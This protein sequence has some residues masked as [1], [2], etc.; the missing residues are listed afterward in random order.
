MTH[1]EPAV[2]RPRLFATACMI[3]TLGAC[4]LSS[5]GETRAQTTIRDIDRPTR[6]PFQIT[7]ANELVAEP[8]RIV[9]VVNVPLG[10]RLVIEHASVQV[11]VAPTPDRRSLVN[12]FLRTQ[13]GGEVA[14]HVLS[15][16]KKRDL[17][18]STADIFQASQP[19]R[20]YADP[21]TTVSALV[22]FNSGSRSDNVDQANINRLTLSGYFVDAR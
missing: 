21:G 11:V 10:K 12:I 19:L 5:A 14:D 6:Q 1:I 22:S 18:A 9:E 16:D 7:L 8:T 4:L 2:S 15:L 17:P 20:V 13:V 3:A